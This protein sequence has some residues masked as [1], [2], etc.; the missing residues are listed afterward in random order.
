MDTQQPTPFS[1]EAESGVIGAA[2]I[3]GI[4]VMDICSEYQLKPDAFYVP[5]HRI[6]YEAMLDLMKAHAPID[7]LTVTE[8]L[9]KKG[10]LD[11]IGGPTQLSRIFDGTPTA[12]HAEYYAE[13]VEAKWRRRLIIAQCRETEARCFDEDQHADPDAILS[14]H[15]TALHRIDETTR[16]QEVSWADT[17]R[18]SM[19][20]TEKIMA[21]QRGMVGISTGFRNLDAALLGL[22]PKDVIIL[23]ARPSM[24]KTSLAM[25]IAEH[26]ALGT[27]DP[28][29]QQRPVGIFSLEMGREQLALRMKC[30]HAKV[31]YWNLVKGYAPKTEYAKLVQ[32]ASV[33]IKAPLYVDDAG[34]LDVQ[35]LR[36]RARRWRDKYGIE[37]LIVDY[38][39]LLHDHEKVK[40]GRQ[41]EVASVSSHM[42]ECAKELEIPVLLLSQLSRKPE[43]KGRE[44]IPQLSDLRDS[45]S[46]EQDAD[47]VLMMRRPCK[48]ERDPEADDETLAL[49]HV[50]KHRNGPTGHAR[51]NFYETFTRFEDRA[52]ASDDDTANS[53]LGIQED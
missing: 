15:A 45:G 33:L 14:D 44:G 50:A 23:A 37:L 27:L 35:Q 40:Q 53:E 30:S 20:R 34:G 2:L 11:S 18:E 26:V 41:M 46:I 7:L 3:D 52:T 42:K 10:K 1:E 49:I 21:E 19:K 29:R 25:N 24:G 17:M 22:K 43:E 6:I 48:Y 28:Q 8:M 38:L 31:S 9:T 36:F 32:A 47:T 5:K 16:L 12:A 4:R 51:L 13:I 39:Q